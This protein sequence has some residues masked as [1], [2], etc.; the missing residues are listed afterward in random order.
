MM[1]IKA[2]R[3]AIAAV[4]LCPL[5][6]AAQAYPTKPIRLIVPVPAGAGPDIDTRQ[7]AS[8]LSP[9]LG[10]PVVVENRPGASTRLAI[11]A[12]AKSAPDGYTFLIA[13]ASFATV[14]SLYANLPF[15]T[16]R[17]FAAVSL[18]SKTAY[19]LTVNTTVPAQTV[20]TYIAL[21]KSNPAYA[22]VATLGIGS[23]PHLAGAWFASIAG[24]D[25]KF[26][27]Y[28]TTSPINDL[29]AAQTAAMFEA[30]L[31]MIGGIKGGKL[32]ALALSGSTRHSLMPDVPTF[33]EA[34]VPGFDPSVWAGV[35]AP[36]AT[37]R[38]IIQ[39][40]SGALSQ[41][42][43]TPEIVAFRRDAGSVSL[44]ST[45]EEFA[46]FLDAEREKWGKVVQSLGLKLE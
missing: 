18:M 2:L 46:T 6:A 38:P 43:K 17:D 24:A 9:L 13:T 34:G 4:T 35:V 31:P 7:I 1:M 41:I 21:T 42:A 26:I 40:V 30:T 29:L 14:Q 44:G 15:D 11:E 3:T 25:L 20:S 36:A 10:Q 33:A 22:P 12:A 32:R 23:F 39:R 45:P 16:V 5:L 8:R 27:H 28:N 19:L 37:P